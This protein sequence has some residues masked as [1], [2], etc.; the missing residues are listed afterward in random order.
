[1]DVE[2]RPREGQNENM[3]T[4][5][6]TSAELQ[7]VAHQ[8]GVFASQLQ[9]R[10]QAC[11]KLILLRAARGGGLDDEHTACSTALRTVKQLVLEH[12]GA[13]GS[14]DCGLARNPQPI[15]RGPA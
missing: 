2:A 11:L 1:M 12:D 15:P 10:E 5:A 9:P 3:K 4:P 6:W 7:A 8:L 14:T 13:E